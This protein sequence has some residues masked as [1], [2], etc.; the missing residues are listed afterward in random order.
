[1]MKNIAVKVSAK[2]RNK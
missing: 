2:T 1:M